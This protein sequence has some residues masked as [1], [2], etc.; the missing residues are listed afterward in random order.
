[1]KSLEGISILKSLLRADSLFDWKVP[2]DCEHLAT[3]QNALIQ[4]NFSVFFDHLRSI[5]RTLPPSTDQQTEQTFSQRKTASRGHR[6]D[7]AATNF[8][9]GLIAHATITANRPDSFPQTISSL[10]IADH[11]TPHP[12]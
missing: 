12:S 10:S 6:P 8:G 1:L 3:P 11:S 4:A 5:D 7:I 9:I 2:E